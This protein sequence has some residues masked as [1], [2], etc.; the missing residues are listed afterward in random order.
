M[1]HIDASTGLAA[2]IGCPV[3]HS[4]SPF[5]HNLAFEIT[6]V[7]MRYLAFSVSPENLHDAIKGLKALG[8]R[9]ANVTVPHKESV[10]AWLDDLSPHGK[11][12]G[13][14]N[15]IVFE[16]GEA[17]GENTDWLGF[18]K[19]WDEEAGTSL[20]GS[21]ALI[22]GTG[23]SAR[24]VYYAL[25]QSGAGAI[26]LAARSPAKG[27]GLHRHFEGLFPSLGR[28]VLSF[29][30]CA[31]L[32]ESFSRADVVINCTPVG[33]APGEEL[34]P[35]AVP[36]GMEKKPLVFDIVYNPLETALMRDAA[37]KG[38]RAFSGLSMLLHQG[39]LAFELWTG[40]PFPLTQIRAR[41]Q[42][43]YKKGRIT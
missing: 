32:A 19:A 41:L 25:G 20:K 14:V 26:T 33:M 10:I 7:P 35:I 3:R 13:A 21:H 27:E 30:D 42:E 12:L 36:A 31:A 34:S 39:A 28:E 9:G 4:L 23:G 22:L 40:T 43:I 8:V 11:I 38:L 29:A 37:S 18:L 2:L 24:A 5:I 1:A 6:G 16:K 15:T 17:R